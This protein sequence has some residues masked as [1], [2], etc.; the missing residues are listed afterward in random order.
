MISAADFPHVFSYMSVHP[1]ERGQATRL[2]LPAPGCIARWED[3]GGRARADRPEVSSASPD[4]FSSFATF[5]VP[6]A[7]AL[8]T[9][10]L[11]SVCWS[12]GRC[13]PAP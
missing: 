12:D 7:L 2:E 9:L 10:A 6:P 8:V 5:A 13:G 1:S 11:F 3:D 4:R